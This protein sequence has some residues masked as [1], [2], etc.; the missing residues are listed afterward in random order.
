MGTGRAALGCR[1]AA[2]LLVALGAAVLPAAAST[3]P[4]IEVTGAT[5]LP[6][7]VE[8]MD[9]LRDPTRRLD[10]A[11]VQRPD[12]ATAFAPA[13][14][15]IPNLGVGRDAV[16]AR[17]A[18]HNAS[19]QPV[20]LLLAL[21]D[22]RTAQVAFWALDDA[23]QVISARRDGRF[24]DPADRDRSHRWFLFDL[25]LA[26]DA[27]A[28]VYLRVTS[29]MGRRLDLRLTD[30]LRLATADRIAYGW[31]GL[32][33]GAL[34]FMLAYNL[35]LL[36]QLREAS[37][38]WLCSLIAGVGLWVADREGLLTTLTWRLWPEE[39]S[40]NQ[41]GVALGLIGVF[42]FPVSFLRL[43]EH[44]PRLR[45]MH[46][47]LAAVMACVPFLYRVSPATA[48]GLS[49]VLG[50][51]GGTAMLVSGALALRWQRRAASQYLLAWSP[52]LIAILLVVL[53]NYALTPSLSFVWV[54]TYASVLLMLLLLSV[55][56][57]DRMNALR[58]RAERA[59]AALAQNEQRLTEL[60]AERTR[61]LAVQRDRAE[62][63]NRAKTRFLANMSHELRTPLNAVLG[64]ADLLRRSRRLDAEAQGHCGLIQ[65]G[66]RHLLR[67]IED[68]L[69]IARIEHDR[70][71]PLLA[72]I[73]LRPMLEDLAAVTRRA[74]EARGLA[75]RAEFAD[76]LPQ[77]VRTDGRRLRQVLQNLLDNAV[78]YTDAGGVCLSVAPDPVASPADDAAAAVLVFTVSDTGCGIAQADQERLFAP[79]EQ[80]DHSRDG[81]GLGLAI[82]RELA[83]V[84]GGELSVESAPGRGSRFRFRLPVQRPAAERTETDVGRA[85]IIGYAGPRRR[86]LVIDDS[87]VNRLLMAGL[88]GHLGFEVDTAEG[89]DAA[90]AIACRRR[91]E[92][93]I[94]DLRM[95]GT[96]GYAA[97]WQLRAALGRPSLPVIAASASPLPAAG[98]AALLGFDAFVLKPIEQGALCAAIADCLGLRWL[99][100]AA[101]ERD[102]RLG[103]MPA[104]MP[105]TVPPPAPPPRIELDTAAELATL[106]DWAALRDWS[107]ELEDAFPECAEFARRVRGLLDDIDAGADAATGAEAALHQLL[108][109]RG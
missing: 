33:F 44:A 96:C 22:P 53:T 6:L 63:A 66:G 60:V 20:A 35:M 41:A 64:G 5:A 72:D 31:L 15:G 86:I 69:D 23:G 16:W 108:A 27:T 8:R 67:L 109:G 80:F 54:L 88:L 65:R 89:A 59:Q 104:P 74:A 56:Q 10:L 51:L 12:I 106:G 17:F 57:A 101:A 68:L 26:T 7:Q 91:P 52:L 38:F 46:I 107:T 98:D 14:A 55:A 71:R 48:Y 85:P 83:G 24:A 40:G 73:E 28:T 95:P 58:R 30:R 50:L 47:A 94:V 11:Q 62:T 37:Y 103:H 97:C 100:A 25:P 39:W 2:W 3:A 36:L 105:T 93:A 77:Q 42:M 90:L 87:E 43:R 18:V 92:L 32:F 81:S 76:D 99:R 45:R 78:K 13:A 29:D 61:E 75:F 79:F 34:L 9:L 82:C 49:Q 21:N 84:L 1:L 70:L 19:G 102:Q 4:L